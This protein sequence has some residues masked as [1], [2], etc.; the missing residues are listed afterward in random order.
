MKSG[1]RFVARMLVPEEHPQG[2]PTWT[3]F[4][5]SDEVHA[6]HRRNRSHDIIDMETGRVF[7]RLPDADGDTSIHISKAINAAYRLGR[8]TGGGGA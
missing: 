3:G 5:V 6:K 4:G 8:A 2:V 1:D 7:L